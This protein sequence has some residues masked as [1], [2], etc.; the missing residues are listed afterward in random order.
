MIHQK[1]VTRAIIGR[2][3]SELLSR[4]ELD[5]AI[6]GAGPSGLVAAYYLV[7]TGKKLAEL[8]AKR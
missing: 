1:I 4:L 2:Y 6:R 7:R 8:V 5:V 3:T